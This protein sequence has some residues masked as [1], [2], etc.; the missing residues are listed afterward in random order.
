MFPTYICSEQI[1]I[2]D[3]D[4]LASGDVLDQ[5][6]RQLLDNL[7]EN[8]YHS[9]RCLGV[10]FHGTVHYRTGNASKATSLY[11]KNDATDGQIGGV[12]CAL[13]H[14][15]YGMLVGQTYY[16]EPNV[17][18]DE[19]AKGQGKIGFAVTLTPPITIVN[20]Y[21]RA[22]SSLGATDFDENQHIAIYQKI[23]DAFETFKA[24]AE[25]IVDC[26]EQAKLRLKAAIG[27]LNRKRAAY[28]AEDNALDAPGGPHGH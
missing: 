9:P 3:F 10:R 12:S 13:R 23:D 8:G 26:P 1:Y 6:A 17:S 4:L 15:V 20:V 14:R 22:S 21:F 16:T 7:G 18:Y 2:R 27:R 11:G 25:A 19:V 24:E 28:W 5:V